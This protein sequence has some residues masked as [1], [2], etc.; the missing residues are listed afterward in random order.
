MLLTRS[1]TPDRFA[2]S[3]A[4]S[5]IVAPSTP[6]RSLLGAMTGA[7]CINLLFNLQDQRLEILDR[8]G[9]V[10][11]L[12]APP[13]SFVLCKINRSVVAELSPGLSIAVRH[14]Y[15]LPVALAALSKDI[16]GC[17]AAAPTA[18]FL[19][20]ARAHEL[21]RE[22]LLSFE[23]G[24]LRTASALPLGLNPY[25]L[26]QLVAAREFIAA[27]RHER[28]TLSRIGRAVG[29]NRTKLALGFKTAFAQTVAEALRDSRLTWAAEQISADKRPIAQIGHEA[30]YPNPASF[31][32]AFARRFGVPPRQYRSEG[33]TR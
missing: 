13:A 23:R 18:R 10:R 15:V 16:V 28:L 29:L 2:A 1:P 33:Q 25:E 3:E 22:T 12:A 21:V 11:L 7:D 24:D 32:R 5:V 9:H 17:V 26:N 4:L 27:R 6:D 19:R 14:A 20:A 8:E 30:G 31:S